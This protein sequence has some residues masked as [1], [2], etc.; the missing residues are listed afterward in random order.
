M[1]LVW[2]L[3]LI[4]GCTSD[5]RPAADATRAPAVAAA[6]PVRFVDVTAASGLDFTHISGSPQQRYI[7]ETAGGGAAFVDYDGDGYLDVFVVNG[8]RVEEQ[9]EEAHNRLFQNV[10]ASPAPGRRQFR[11]VTEEAG[12]KRSG[13]GMG[14]ATGDYDNDGDVDLY[15]TYWGANVLHRNEGDG[16]FV[17]VTASA[18]VGDEGWGSSAAFGDVDGDGQLDLYVG[19][20]LVFDL[21]A[22][23]NDGLPCGALKGLRGFCGP[24]GMEAQADVLYRN[25]GQGRFADMGPQT[26]IDRYAYPTLGVIFGDYDQDGD[27]DIYVA[28]DVEPNQLWRNDGGWRLSE[29]GALAGVAYSEDGRAQAGMGVDFGDYDNDGDLDLYVTNFSDDVNTLYRN[30]ADGT[31]VDATALS[32]LEGT[33]R[34][35][36]GWSTALF[37]ADS[38]GWLDLFVANGH[39]YPQLE[40]HPSVLRYPQRNLFYHNQE[41]VFRPVDAGPGMEVEKVSRG[42]AFGDYDNDGDVDLLVMNLNDAP[43]LLRNEGG[44]TN[45]WL[46]L[47]LV[48]ITSNRDAIGARVRVQA[49]E[50]A[51]VREVRRGYGYQSQ[52]DPRLLF[53][54]GSRQRVERVEILWP[55]G[56]RQQLEDLPLRRYFVVRE[57]SADVLAGDVVP[58]DESAGTTPASSVAASSAA[59]A[60]QVGQPDWTAKDYFRAGVSFYEQARH[61]EAQAAFEHAVELDP[62]YAVAYVNLGIVLYFKGNYQE[63]AVAVERAARLDPSRAETFGLLGR[64]Y[65]GLN[66]PDLALV[67]LDR[68]TRLAPSVWEYHHWRGL[69]FVRADSTE[70]AVA[71]FRQASTHAPWEP[72]PHQ[73]LA[74]QYIELSRPQ[75]AVRE[76]QLFEQLAPRKQRVVRY[77]REIE[78]YPEKAGLRN[79]LGRAYLEQGRPQEAL[80]QFELAIELDP[81]YGLAHYGS[82]AVLHLQKQTAL[83]ISAYEEACRVQP[84]LFEAFH[85]LGQAYSQTEQYEKAIIAYRKALALQADRPLVHSNLGDIYATQRRF[86]QAARSYETALEMNPGLTKTRDLLGRVYAAQARLEE[87]IRE[88]EVVLQQDPDHPYAGTLLHRARQKLSQK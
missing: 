38:D 3:L 58:Q 53:G 24:I 13:W 37:D 18:G 17:D 73:S 68:A 6:A 86:E 14:C 51:L 9:P 75:L 25:M 45:N 40:E 21:A 4:Y 76:Q 42:A 46:G 79:K 22:P 57:G 7:L 60:P 72:W 80:R 19:N 77:Q 16:T 47:Q 87:A 8:T 20:Y 56:R 71:A 35:Y 70:A 54:L 74:R 78:E 59:P 5:S 2:S 11:E 39:V 1:K 44:N 31:F 84:D 10:Q 43:T 49:G 36:L 28:N 64:F 61:G 34:P 23:P 81:E 15:V 12:L 82:G 67:A 50:L 33:A 30:Q 41:G 27:Q 65:L 55:S 48:G 66:R 62:D 85:D 88:W 32:G 26:G 69:A 29:V 63:A 83:A 52:H